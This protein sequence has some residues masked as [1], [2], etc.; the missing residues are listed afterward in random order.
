MTRSNL[1]TLERLA[2]LAFRLPLVCHGFV[3]LKRK[4]DDSESFGNA[5]LAYG[6]NEMRFWLTCD[7]NFVEADVELVHGRSGRWPLGLLIDYDRNVLTDRS[8]SF[9][10]QGMFLFSRYRRV[11]EILSTDYDHLRSW[12]ARRRERASSSR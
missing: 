3:L 10:Q 6:N 9:W 11:K 5:L 2:G 8:R 1:R 4:F 7:R 12:A